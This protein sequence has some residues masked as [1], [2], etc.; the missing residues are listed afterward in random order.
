MY[1]ITNHVTESIRK[2]LEIDP[3]PGFRLISHSVTSTVKKRYLG[4]GA[5]SVDFQEIVYSCLWEKID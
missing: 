4:L 3:I 1:K 2:E 5:P